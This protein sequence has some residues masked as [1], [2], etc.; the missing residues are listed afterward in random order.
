M[1]YMTGLKLLKDQSQNAAT[2]NAKANI[3]FTMAAYEEHEGAL[4]HLG[5]SYEKG[6]C[7]QKDLGLAAHF[8]AWPPHGIMSPRNVIWQ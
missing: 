3:W 8:I 7:V 2:N 6:R 5:V 1:H 4:F